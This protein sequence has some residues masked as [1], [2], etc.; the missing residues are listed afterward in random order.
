MMV[1]MASCFNQGDCTI[2]S[3]N[4][5]KVTFQKKLDGTVKSTVFLTVKTIHESDTLLLT[6]QDP[7][8][9]I[10]VTEMSLPMN[11]KY[12]ST[13][14][15]LERSDQRLF[16]LTLSYTT[17][18]KVI[19]TDCGAFLYYQDLKVKSTNFDSTRV[20]NTQLLTSVG[21]NLQIFM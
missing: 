4:L 11:P 19:A 20:V 1:F 12:D 21:K 5:V 8:N 3:T 16:R 6:S 14:F 10:P 7:A 18:S 13:I 15:L 9:P 17:Y 2:T